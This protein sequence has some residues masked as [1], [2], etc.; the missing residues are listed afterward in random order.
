MVLPLLA[1]TWMSAVLAVTDR[2]SALFQI[3]FAVFDSLE[4]FVIVMV[5]CVLRREVGAGA[6]RGRG[7]PRGGAAA[8]AFSGPLQ[9]WPGQALAQLRPAAGGQVAGIRAASPIL[10]GPRCGKTCISP[11][12]ALARPQGHWE[13]SEAERRV[14]RGPPVGGAGHRRARTPTGHGGGRGRVDSVSFWNLPECGGQRDE[15]YAKAHRPG[16]MRRTGEGPG[17]Q[18]HTPGPGELWDGTPGPRGRA[19]VGLLILHLFGEQL[20]LPLSGQQ[21]P[22]WAPARG[23]PAQGGHRPGGARAIE[24]ADAAL[25]TSQ[26]KDVY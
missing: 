3:L 13:S 1:L 8:L 12:V 25:R 10:E 6:G 21:C 2:R 9:R 19:R 4:G 24:G 16:R 14:T 18:A 26:E 11:S 23:F 20:R 22:L 17:Q 5:H 15:G 7:G